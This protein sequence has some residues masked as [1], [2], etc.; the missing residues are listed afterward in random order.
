MVQPTV[1]LI[2]FYSMPNDV[3]KAPDHIIGMEPEKTSVGQLIICNLGRKY[4]I[5]A[6]CK[7]YSK[8][9]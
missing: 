9:S 2:S 8:L 6:L 5:N 7:S 1:A 3:Y 4:K